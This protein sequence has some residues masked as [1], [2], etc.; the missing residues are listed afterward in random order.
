MPIVM[1]EPIVQNISEQS[2]SSSVPTLEVAEPVLTV[3]NSTVSENVPENSSI[4][5]I[6]EKTAADLNIGPGVP[7]PV[8]ATTI[9]NAGLAEADP[10]TTKTT[11]DPGLSEADP[12]SIKTSAS[13]LISGV[14]ESVS[15]IPDIGVSQVPSIADSGASPVSTEVKDILEGENN[16]DSDNSLD[17][18]NEIK[19]STHNAQENG[20]QNLEAP[21]ISP[22]AEAPGTQKPA[23]NSTQTAQQPAQ[24][25]EKPATIDQKPAEL[26]AI[27]QK[28]A[29]QDIKQ[30]NAEL[31]N[32]PDDLIA[33]LRDEDRNEILK[34]AGLNVTEVPKLAKEELENRRKSIET[35]LPEGQ[36][37]RLRLE[38]ECR[39]KLDLVFLLDTSG[40]IEQIYKEHVK[41]A[42]A[43]VDSLPLEPDAVRVAAVQ[44]A[45]FPLTEFALGTYPSAEDIR[46]HLEQIKFQSGVTRTGYALRKAELELF[47]EDRGARRDSVKAI[48]LFTDGLSVD[49]PAKPAQQ[50]RDI[51][52]VKI[53]VVN[54]GTDSFESEMMKIAG[55]QEN[56]FGLFRPNDLQRLREAVLN[57]AERARGCSRV[58]PKIY[59][60]RPLKKF[61]TEGTPAPVL[62]PLSAFEIQEKLSE[63]TP[64]ITSSRPSIEAT[65]QNSIN[66]IQE[67]HGEQAAQEIQTMQEA[68]AML[69]AVRK[70]Q[71][72]GPQKVE[73]VQVAP[74][75]VD[76]RPKNVDAKQDAQEQNHLRVKIPTPQ[77]NFSNDGK[78]NKLPKEES[79]KAKKK[80]RAPRPSTTPTPTTTTQEATSKTTRRRRIRTTTSSSTT[81]Q[82]STTTTR[83]PRLLRQHTSPRQEASKILDLNSR[84]LILLF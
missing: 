58:G 20:I 81:T 30:V 44:Y 23:E 4:S 71:K 59:E 34:L 77:E 21:K 52:G 68:Q 74:K 65:T 73:R 56:I 66:V 83:R 13:V 49:D 48:I 5:T 82:P 3:S 37:R 18:D 12:G 11:S 84:P 43:L 78:P 26:A 72:E 33:L 24:I 46:A 19:E 45:G 60:R 22:I 70:A 53:Y 17:S 32:I 62:H 16:E 31:L 41:W 76:V 15:A 10:E 51:K 36:K 47:R 8:L 67:I 54:I 57:D 64:S 75:K 6:S 42:V 29:I 27:D 2:P 69:E 1:I 38:D 55:K 50:L 9:S 14:P 35:P 28:P 80:I 39:P 79:I 7:E 61:V 63:V 25:D 40:S